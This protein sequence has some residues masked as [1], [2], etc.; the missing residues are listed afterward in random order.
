MFF[1]PMKSVDL[2]PCKV[3]TYA[4][5]DNFDPVFGTDSSRVDKQIPKCILYIHDVLL[6]T[7]VTSWAGVI[8]ASLNTL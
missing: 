1:S 8:Y 2:N 6:P 3:P 5:P 7:L 4:L